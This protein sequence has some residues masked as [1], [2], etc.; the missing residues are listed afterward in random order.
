MIHAANARHVRGA[1]SPPLHAVV[2]RLEADVDYPMVTYPSILDREWVQKIWRRWCCPRGWHLFDE[3]RG[4]GYQY[5]HCD[6]CGRRL[7]YRDI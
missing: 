3:V 2:R 5:L 1:E 7:G 4:R 6:A